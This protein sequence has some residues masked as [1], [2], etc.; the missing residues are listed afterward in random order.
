MK[1]SDNYNQRLEIQ[2]NFSDIPEGKIIIGKSDSTIKISVSGEGYKMLGLSGNAKNALDISLADINLISQDNQ[3]LIGVISTSS[4][5]STINNQ[6]GVVI[7]EKNIEPEAI[8]VTLD[9]ID[10]AIIPIIYNA[11]IKT[12]PGFR[13]YGNAKITPDKTEVIGPHSIIDTIHNIY[14]QSFILNDINNSFQK[15]VQLKSPH[16]T[17]N[18]STKKVE[19]N[20]EIVEFIEA[21][22][23]VPIKIISQIP[24]LQIKTFPSTIKLTYQVA[25]PDYKYMSDSLFSVV[26]E[27]DSLTALRRST[28]IPNIIKYPAGIENLKMDTE[29]IE[30]IIL[31][32]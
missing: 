15:E 31:N 27:I 5:R 32:K 12:T 26:V 7:T 28:L 4:L 3:T 29:K 24:N 1:L 10:T 14:T 9:Y 8:T 2:I 18:L 13:L 6:L 21:E 25:M 30:F 11:Q 17:V 22:T 23:E 20:V 16:P 19:I